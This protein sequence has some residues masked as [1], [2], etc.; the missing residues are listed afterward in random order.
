MRIY[1]KHV[2]IQNSFAQYRWMLPAQ[3]HHSQSLITL[4]SN[5]FF[6]ICSF[7]PFYS[8]FFCSCDFATTSLILPP[9][10]LLAWKFI[11]IYFNS[12]M[13]LVDSRIAFEA[14]K[15]AT[16]AATAWMQCIGHRARG[17][18]D[19]FKISKGSI[20]W[21]QKVIRWKTNENVTWAFWYKRLGRTPA[22]TFRLKIVSLKNLFL[23]F[24]FLAGVMVFFPRK[25]R[26]FFFGNTTWM[27][28]QSRYF[29]EVMKIC[30]FKSARQE[31]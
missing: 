28:C 23:Y 9:N 2:S 5:L 8:F 13:H 14:L 19:L 15:S 1:A 29:R 6:T 22:L 17:R 12:L 26:V 31:K 25:N 7:T 30:D 10:P 3:I 16:A 27:K 11:P 20:V 18:E 24:H 4:F 21:T